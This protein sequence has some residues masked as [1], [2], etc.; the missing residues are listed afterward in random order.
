MTSNKKDGIQPKYSESNHQSEVNPVSNV[1][2]NYPRTH[3]LSSIMRCIGDSLKQIWDDYSV[4]YLVVR[5]VCPVTFPLHA[6][7]FYNQRLLIRGHSMNL[8]IPCC[9]FSHTRS[10][11]G[12]TQC[13]C[14]SIIFLH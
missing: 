11:P 8:I 14:E 2:S 13:F 3:T 1:N 4:E 6:G 10:E 12:S 9:S 7:P 5:D